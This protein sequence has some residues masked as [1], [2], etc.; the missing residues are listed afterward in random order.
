MADGLRDD[1]LL[2]PAREEGEFVADRL[3]ARSARVLAPRQQVVAA[4]ELVDIGKAKETLEKL[5]EVSNRP[6]EEP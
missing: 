3:H 1:A 4:E 2:A 6:E 5:I